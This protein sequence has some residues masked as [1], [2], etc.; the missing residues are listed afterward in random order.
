[1]ENSVWTYEVAKIYAIRLSFNRRDREQNCP[2]I[3]VYVLTMLGTQHR[4]ND[5]QPYRG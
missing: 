5:N 2:L 4:S 3:W 1:M